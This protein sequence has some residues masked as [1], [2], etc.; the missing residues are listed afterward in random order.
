MIFHIIFIFKKGK[1]II[2]SLIWDYKIWVI[3]WNE[4]FKI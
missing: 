2:M 4:E 1:F 3:K